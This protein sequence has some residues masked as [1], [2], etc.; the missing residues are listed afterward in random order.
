[1]TD[2]DTRLEKKPNLVQTL[3]KAGVYKGMAVDVR[4]PLGLARARVH[5]PE[6]HG[7][8]KDLNINQIY[9]ALPHKALRG[10]HTP[11]EWGDKLLVSFNNGNIMEPQIVGYWE[12]IPNGKGTLSFNVVQGTDTRAEGWWHHDW[13]PESLVLAASGEGCAIWFENKQLGE[14]DLY[15]A[16]KLCDTGGKFFNVWSWHPQTL[17]YAATEKI[18][19]DESLHGLSMDPPNVT[20]TGTH[21]IIV[22]VGGGIDFGHQNLKRSM[23]ADDNSFTIDQLWQK[24][25]SGSSGSSDSSSSS[26]GD[27]SDS[28]SSDSS[29]GGLSG[30]VSSDSSTASTTGIDVA[31]IGGDLLVH[32]EGRAA[33]TMMK[34]SMFLQGKLVFI[35]KAIILPRSWSNSG[36]SSSSSS[37]SGSG[38][39]VSGQVI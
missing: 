5:I 30:G 29:S 36:S 16:I 1:M 13:Y 26:S 28:S 27:S 14:S 19:A 25:S 32:R 21:P 10:S 3:I 8:Y 7:D 22:Q 23:L 11:P 4:D 6:L 12:S 31:A 34:D 33:H 17:D 15:S 2:V 37:G 24:S 18:D 20:R 35:N 38:N 39:Q 9:W